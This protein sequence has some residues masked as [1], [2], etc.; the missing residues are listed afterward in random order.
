MYIN[1]QQ[2]L[3]GKHSFMSHFFH[4][5]LYRINT[6]LE[7]FLVMWCNKF[8]FSFSGI[9]LKLFSSEVQSPDWWICGCDIPSL[10]AHA[11]DTEIKWLWKRSH[12]ETCNKELNY[13]D[14][15][16][17][18]DIGRSLLFASRDEQLSDCRF[19]SRGKR[20]FQL[21]LQTGHLAIKLKTL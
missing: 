19:F 2:V 20:V 8:Y 12:Q 5:F 16:T 14:A 4:K 6:G 15:E 13:L 21:R 7:L 10:P 18:S 17:G 1:R 9:S 11:S 3:Q